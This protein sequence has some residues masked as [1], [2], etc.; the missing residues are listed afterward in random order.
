MKSYDYVTNFIIEYLPKEIRK[1]QDDILTTINKRRFLIDEYKTVPSIIVKRLRLGSYKPLYDQY[2]YEEVLSDSIIYTDGP[3][4][5]IK[6]QF[7][8]KKCSEELFVYILFKRSV[9]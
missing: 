9:L 8:E 4:Y 7:V 2:F 3:I 6:I 5:E 1:Y